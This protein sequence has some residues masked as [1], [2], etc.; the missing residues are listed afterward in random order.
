VGARLETA[1]AA[2]GRRAVTDAMVSLVLLLVV[3]APAAIYWVVDRRRSMPVKRSD[4]MRVLE[5]V[6]RRAGATPVPGSEAERDT[7]LARSVRILG[8]HGVRPV[9]A[10]AVTARHRPRARSMSPAAIAARRAR[11]QRNAGSPDTIVVLGPQPPNDAVDVE[12]AAVEA[13]AIVG[14]VP[15]RA[16]P[17]RQSVWHR[18]GAALVGVVAIGAVALAGAHSVEGRAGHGAVVAAPAAPAVTTVVE[19]VPTTE[20][21]RRSAVA[22]DGTHASIGTGVRYHLT[23]DARGLCW[24]RVTQSDT[25]QVLL[26]TTLQPNQPRQ[27]DLTGRTHMRVGAAD[28]V[29]VVVDGQTVAL[30]AAPAGPY[31]IDFSGAA[32]A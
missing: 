32:L 12:A 10:D 25:G 3:G 5:E 17:A 6:V 9:P 15:R 11:A 22:M 29:T 14:T 27:L 28:T 7:D 18:R 31:D 16:R 1:V 23:V 26:E 13:D 20:R 21:P 8:G 2:T 4:A 24:L 30:P 19:T